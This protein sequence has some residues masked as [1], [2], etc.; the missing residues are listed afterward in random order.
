VL[1][2]LVIKVAEGVNDVQEYTIDP[3]IGA[4]FKVTVPPVPQKVAGEAVIT[5]GATVT[6]TAALDPSQ[7]PL[8]SATYSVPE[9]QAG[10]VYVAPIAVMVPPF[11]TLYQL[12]VP[13][14]PVAVA[15]TSPPKLT[16]AEAGETEGAAGAEEIVM[17]C[18]PVI[19]AP[20]LVMAA[21]PVV[22]APAK[23]VI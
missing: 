21:K 12:K 4:T 14:P 9:A 22:P 19:V 23:P 5:V 17:V 15:V 7:D 3:S 16:L 18:K 11:A 8:F 10:P 1:P 20:D 6:E 2:V 13:P